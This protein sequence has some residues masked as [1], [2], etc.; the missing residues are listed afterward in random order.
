MAFSPKTRR[1]LVILLVLA[2]SLTLIYSAAVFNSTKAHLKKETLY[3]N[4]RLLMGTFWEVTSPDKKAA[5]IVFSEAGRI[6]QLL[7]KY[8]AN[9]EV[10]QLNHLGKL[11]V[12]PETFYII[13]KSKEFW[14]ESS[15]AFD[16]T[17]A[18]LVD[19]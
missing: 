12:S 13:K 6:E 18:G 4:N 7:S 17:V 10:S 9:S 19:L 8:I 14:Q 1:N 11:K 2:W 16:I 15:G 3:R 5:G